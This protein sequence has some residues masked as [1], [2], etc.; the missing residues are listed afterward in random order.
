MASPSSPPKTFPITVHKVISHPDSS[1]V[2]LILN[3]IG[4]FLLLGSPLR[5]VT[6]LD[7]SDLVQCERTE[8]TTE[9][10]ELLKLYHHRFDDEWVDLDL[11]MDLL[12]YIFSTTS[13]GEP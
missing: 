6:I 8:V 1:V 10:Q 9:E 7:E 2:F 12:H 13:E 3:L 4:L 5:E 11:I